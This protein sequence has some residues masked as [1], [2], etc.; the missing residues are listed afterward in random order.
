MAFDLKKIIKRFKI[1]VTEKTS[2]RNFKRSTSGSDYYHQ[3]QVTQVQELESLRDIN[4]IEVCMGILA[5]FI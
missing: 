5:I 2:N 4:V 1:V 3:P